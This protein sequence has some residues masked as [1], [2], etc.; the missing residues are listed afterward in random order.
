MRANNELLI[1]TIELDP[2]PK[3]C[4]YEFLIISWH[5]RLNTD[6]P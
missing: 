2:Q 4:E 3:L 5:Q 6:T 1:L